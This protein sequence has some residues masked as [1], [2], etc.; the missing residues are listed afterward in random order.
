MH[1][2]NVTALELN[3]IAKCLPH[4]PDMAEGST[5][6]H[7]RN[8]VDQ[9]SALLYNC[10][11]ILTIFIKEQRSIQEYIRQ[12]RGDWTQGNLSY[13]SKKFAAIYYRLLPLAT[14]DQK[15][16]NVENFARQGCENSELCIE[17]GARFR[18]LVELY[19]VRDISKQADIANALMSQ[20]SLD[21]TSMQQDLLRKMIIQ[22]IGMTV[23]DT[24][25][26]DLLMDALPIVL[27]PEG[28][29]EWKTFIDGTKKARAQV[30]ELESMSHILPCN[31]VWNAIFT[32]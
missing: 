23:P 10:P 16:T 32:P 26:V 7:Q 14:L 13:V 27:N 4:A 9:E 24:N 3:T 31:I 2:K 19:R 22:H 28:C 12:L 6:N 25:S 29:T 1:E 17:F 20:S 30:E 15:Q 21:M 18:R 8:S 11:S 5:M